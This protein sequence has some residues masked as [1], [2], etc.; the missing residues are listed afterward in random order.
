MIREETLAP[1][2]SCV[3]AF[4]PS[5]VVGTL[6]TQLLSAGDV[7]CFQGVGPSGLAGV[8][9]AQVLRMGGHQPEGRHCKQR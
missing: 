3:S 2:Q 1:L 9:G 8:C 4:G 5:R 6:C 7:L